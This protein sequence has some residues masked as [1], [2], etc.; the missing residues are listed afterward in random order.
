MRRDFNRECWLNREGVLNREEWLIREGLD[1]LIE[2]GF[3]T[4]VR[5]SFIDMNDI[6]NITYCQSISLTK[7]LSYFQTKKTEFTRLQFNN[8]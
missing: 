8:R 3:L 4:V 2:R 6:I 5:T 1:Q 7:S